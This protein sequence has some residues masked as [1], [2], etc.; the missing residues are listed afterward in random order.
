MPI[1]GSVVVASE[2]VTMKLLIGKRDVE[3]RAGG[4]ALI[5]LA[6]LCLFFLRGHR[7]HPEAQPSTLELCVALAAVCSGCVG[8]GL[9]FE[10]RRLFDPVTD[11]RARRNVH[12]NDS[13]SGR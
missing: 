10:G 2:M 1:A 9:L 5:L 4:A 12:G 6:A 7:G 8:A 11:P 3:V 13:R